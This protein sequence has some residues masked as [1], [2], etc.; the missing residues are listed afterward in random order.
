MSAPRS[1]AAP[2][3]LALGVC[4]LALAVPERASIAT[5]AMARACEQT[6]HITHADHAYIVMRL[7][8]YNDKTWLSTKPVPL[9]P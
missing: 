1:P 2:V 6:T 8:P 3:A 9:V 4:D 5:S 7:I